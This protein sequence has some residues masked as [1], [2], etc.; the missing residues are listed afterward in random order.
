MKILETAPR[1]LPNNPI[2]NDSR[3]DPMQPL[4]PA[5][6]R[7]S[8]LSR[9]LRTELTQCWAMIEVREKE[10]ANAYAE[11]RR[12]SDM[13]VSEVTRRTEAE[14]QIAAANQMA[15]SGQAMGTVLEYVASLRQQ[16][17]MLGVELAAT[18]HRIA[19]L[20]QQ[21]VRPERPRLV[22][23]N[24]TKGT[25]PASSYQTVDRV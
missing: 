5:R 6:V 3:S 9:R 13:L 1:L 2:S 21:V 19:E 20:S 7:E 16:V 12:I 18:H 24:T 14:K 17:E 8:T 23:N 22:S 10:L 4:A 11:N 25:T 15:T